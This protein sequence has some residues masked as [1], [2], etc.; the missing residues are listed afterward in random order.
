MVQA[1][2]APARVTGARAARLMRR[3]TYASVA[4]ASLLLAVKIGAWLLT[5]SLS[6]LATLV[7]SLLDIAASVLNM[8]AV[9]H[10]VMPA[11]QD[12][13]FGHGKL[14][15]LAA[16]GQAAFVTGS[17]IFLL[18]AAGQRFLYPRPVQDGET[19][20][21]VM[22]VSMAA[23]VALVLYQRRVI[24]KTGSL[25]IRADSLHYL[26]DLLVNGAV[27]LALSLWMSFEWAWVD[28]AFAIG[29]ALYIL[30]TA[31]RIVAGALDM[32]MDREWPQADRAR[33]VEIVKAHPQVLGM[34]DLRTRA[35]GPNSFVQLHLELDGR[36]SLYRANVIA[37][38]I[39]TELHTAFPEVEVI[40]HQDPHG[41]DDDST[42][43]ARAGLGGGV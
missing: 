20:I 12:H 36:M 30:F 18:I 7:D 28:P 8:L 43:L 2:G 33:I 31:G 13:R 38:T 6:L 25:A 1:S 11:D 3:A 17:A 16:L 24:R 29:I 42:P 10:A 14:E 23:T 21:A 15:P 34:H 27:I 19:G 32:L 22:L 39:E 26:S 9:R 35:A 5:D 40:I 4:T 37:D 41:V